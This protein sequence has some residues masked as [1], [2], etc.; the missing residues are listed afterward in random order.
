MCGLAGYIQNHK[1]DDNIDDII[2]QMTNAIAHRG[3]DADG[4][5]VN[6]ERDLALGHRRLSILDLSEAG[7][8]PMI[9]PSGRYVVVFNG[10]IYNFQVLRKVLEESGSSFKGHSDTEVLLNAF[11]AWGIQDTL[12]RI[13][14]MFVIALY[15]QKNKELTFARDRLGKKPLYFGW[16]ANGKNF[17][18]ASELKSIVGLN[19]FKNLEINKEAVQL[20]LRWRYIP[21]P[22]SIYKNIWKLPPSCYFTLPIENFSF[23]FNPQKYF[24]EYWNFEK[25]VDQEKRQDSETQA[26]NGLEKIITGAV[27][28]RMISDV[29]LGAFLSGGIDSSLV[30]ALMQK[31]S[32]KPIDSFTIAF[33]DP[34]YNEAQKAKEISNHLGTNHIEMMMT[35]Q[36]A[37]DTVQSLGQIFDEPFADPSA[38]PTYH[39]C[40]L[41]KTKMT[42]AL[43]GDGGDESFGGYDL[44]KRIQKIVSLM[45][46]PL[47]LRYVAANLLVHIPLPGKKISP[48]QRQKIAMMLKAHCPDDLQPLIHSYW[49]A[50]TGES[51]SD[52]LPTAYSALSKNLKNDNIVERMMAFDT[53]MFLAG[54]VL[55]KV[56]RCSMAHSLEVR[57]PLLDEAVINYAYGM[58]FKYKINNGVQKYALKE[59][60]KRYVPE[61]LIDQKKQG[62][63]I[64]HSQWIRHE[65]KDWVEGLLSLEKLNQYQLIDP[66]KVLP[67]WEAHKNNQ[68]DYGHYL[69]TIICLQNWAVQWR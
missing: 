54:D 62:F 53:R 60:L 3:P 28:R 40:R 61:S 7:A 16:D 50:V 32:A 47:P 41:A 63:S 36:D 27:E 43:S 65:L 9:S 12:R 1:R 8:Q 11:E 18:F 39:V 59:V 68:G 52:T 5:W 2:K 44:Y 21:D 45:S 6:E 35:G 29:P 31:Q 10:E 57:S 48:V 33:D 17:S 46:I 19:G 30:V 55:T 22:Y 23:V 26:I 66:D 64:P 51:L 42:V 14:G 15:D 4:V 49:Y 67:Y 56:D 13:S 25:I 58:D 24:K 34:Q 69:W 20:Y 38:I 37:L